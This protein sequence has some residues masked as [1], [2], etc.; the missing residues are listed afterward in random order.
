[1]GRKHPETFPLH[2]HVNGSKAKETGQVPI[3]KEGKISCGQNTKQSCVK[4]GKVK[5]RH[6]IA[7]STKSG[8]KQERRGGRKKGTRRALTFL[9]NISKQR[10]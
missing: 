8:G 7:N 5:H 9:K 6:S 3:K 4:Q 10:G 2:E 1:M